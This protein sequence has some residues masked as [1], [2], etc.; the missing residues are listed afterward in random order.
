LENLAFKQ[1]CHGFLMAVMVIRESLTTTYADLKVVNYPLEKPFFDTHEQTSAQ[2]PVCDVPPSGPLRFFSAVSM[3]SLISIMTPSW[4]VAPDNTLSS[5][6][7]WETRPAKPPPDSINLQAM[8]R[9]RTRNVAL[10]LD[11]LWTSDNI[12]VTMAMD[13]VIVSSNYNSE[14]SILTQP[15]D[16]Q[17]PTVAAQ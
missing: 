16:A 1:A 5:R 8:R 11:V 15:L 13:I 7:S 6:K 14:R 9:P 3:E 4:K 2:L 12:I 10:P 17:P